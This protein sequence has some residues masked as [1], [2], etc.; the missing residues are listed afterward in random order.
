LPAAPAAKL[1][2]LDISVKPLPPLPADEKTTD[3]GASLGADFAKVE[4]RITGAD[5]GYRLA[6]DG[7]KV[8]MAVKK[9]PAPLTGKITLK[10]QIRL[11]SGGSLRNGFLVFGDSPEEAK[12]VK[13]G[14]RFAQK[15]AVVVQGSFTGGKTTDQPATVEQSKAYPI[16]VTIDLASGQVTMKVASATVTVRLESRPA[17]VSYVGYVTSGAT[18]E[19]GPIDV[20]AN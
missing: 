3:A 6:A 1:E 8:A 15:K 13:C 17:G 20:S 19:F 11:V 7:K 12:L 2:P 16:D 5:L 10:G 14:L 9:L 18:T 4:G